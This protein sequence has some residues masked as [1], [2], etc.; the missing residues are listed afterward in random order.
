MNEYINVSFSCVDSGDKKNVE[1]IGVFLR[2]F[3]LGLDE[4]VDTFVVVHED[5]K[6]IACGGIAKNILKCIA[7][8]PLCR[9]E[10]IS[11]KLLTELTLLAYER[12]QNALFLFTR[13]ENVPLFKESGFYP[14]IEIADEVAVME[15]SPNRLM[16][17]CCQLGLHRHGGKRIGSIVM[18]ANP[19]TLG[20]RYLIEQAA[21][22]CD[23][24]HVFLVKED[25]SYF[26]YDERWRLLN[27][28]VKGI[29]NVTLHPGSDYIISR[30]TFPSYFIKDKKKVN[31]C[32]SQIDLC[33]F[34]RYL[35][36][37]LGITHRFIGTEPFCSLTQD[38]N[39]EMKRILQEP[40]DNVAPLKVIELARLKVKGQP[41]S[42]SKVR[43]L[44][45][46]GEVGKLSTLVPASTFQFLMNK[47]NRQEI[48]SA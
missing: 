46:I 20:H 27:E 47:I 22:R 45:F 33:L 13:P 40:I 5:E 3:E 25:A 8:D 21:S 43:S 32:H 39:R 2:R 38:Y 35:A 48:T 14:L 26:S 34:R 15:N 16:R 18:N 17:Y 31:Y 7:V 42:A 10:G 29:S 28:G 30:M 12:Q 44:L 24:L 9:G 41:V 4:Q 23:W 1:K 37:A 6:L 36:P 19:F 11:A